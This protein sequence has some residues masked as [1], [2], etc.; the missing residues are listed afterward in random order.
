MTEESARWYIVHA[1]SG[2]EQRVEKTIAEMIRS[3]QGEG[4]IE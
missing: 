1:F 2:Y 3:G 4:L